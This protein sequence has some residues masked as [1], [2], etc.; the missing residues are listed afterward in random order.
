MQRQ[1]RVLRVEQLVGKSE[2][3]SQHLRI[4]NQD[5]GKEELLA[6]VVLEGEE[7]R[8]KGGSEKTQHWQITTQA[9]LL[10]VCQNH[11][12]HS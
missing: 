9:R 5:R 3:K 11:V 8:G 10:G 2:F 12:D 4:R 7:R 6:E 1:R